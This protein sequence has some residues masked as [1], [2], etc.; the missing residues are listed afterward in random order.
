MKR[1]FAGCL[2]IFAA[3]MIT[4][5][6][7]AISPADSAVVCGIDSSCITPA[8]DG[9]SA[10]GISAVSGV[11]QIDEEIREEKG[12]YVTIKTTEGDITLLLYD[13]TPLHR[14]N[15]IRL[16][17]DGVYDGVL[18]HRVIKD[19]LI[20]GGDPASKEHV[21]GKAY[22]DGD[23]GYVVYSEIL[24]T[25]FCKRGALIDAKLGDD[26]NPTRMS[27]GTQFCVVQ[28]KTFTDEQLDA[29][30]ERLNEWQKN[31]L[32][33]LAR[34]EL[35]LEDPTLS[36]IENGDLLNAKARE[37]AEKEYKEQGR[38]TISPERREVYRT[39]GGTPHLDGSV[40]VF[41]ELISGQDVVE[42]I[43]EMA[44]DSLDR[45][46]KD[47]IILSTEVHKK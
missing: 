20:Q 42:R 36:K 43:T 1:I 5:Q 18:F 25:R 30:E 44:T 45:P 21:P 33:H 12:T 17:K 10:S 24:P 32:Y 35:M 13:D 3:N 28:G 8:L 9:M 31:Y 27:A 46:L 29:T 34:Y 6:S 11:E 15:F 40:T 14:D 39:I 37:R 23:G 4:S 26:V 47:V 19:F 38:V 41:G 16:C 2:L 7:S 22:G